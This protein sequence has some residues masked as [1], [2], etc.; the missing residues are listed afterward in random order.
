MPIV[1]VIM[2]VYNAE[3]SLIR[4]V[5][6]VLGQDY[7]DLELILVN[8]GSTDKSFNI[9]NAFARADSR[10]KVVHQKN[11]GVSA[12]RNAGI[13]AACG[14]YIFFL[15]SDDYLLP[16]AVTAAMEAQADHPD[17]WLL[18]RYEMG[19]NDR[20]FWGAELD[21]T[22]T[23]QLEAGALAHLYNRCFISMPWNKLYRADIAKNLRFNTDYTL[24]EDLLF[25]LDYLDAL[26]KADDHAPTFA[27]LHRNL[28]HY[29]VAQ[30]SDTLSTRYLPDYCT[31]WQTLFARLNQACEDH[32][33]PEADRKALH[34]GEML[35]LCEGIND[36]LRRDPAPKK[37]RKA[38]AAEVLRSSWLQGLCTWMAQEKNYSPY[39]LPVKWKNLMLL[40]K[41]EE[42]RRA[43]SGFFGKMDW[44]GWYLLG[45][46]WERT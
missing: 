33:C 41:M 6:S 37:Q 29:T 2:P 35:V 31:L 43:G 30:N 45:G 46:K 25:C 16:G 39:Y 44:L 14:A 40:S 38:K 10:V 19:E 27:L 28:T 22:G 13:D 4:S 34:R 23:E 18:W 9:C 26:A 7:S 1:S 15:D 5:G 24:G 42:S 3:K 17:S 36:I 12:A 32:H 21:K 11:S 20:D 8:D